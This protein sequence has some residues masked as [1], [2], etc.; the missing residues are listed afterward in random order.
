MPGYPR[1][2]LVLVLLRP[3]R[4]DGGGGIPVYV[5]EDGTYEGVDA[6]VDKDRAAAV[7][8][9]DIDARTLLFLTDVDNVYLDYMKPGQKALENI[10]VTEARKYMKGGQFPPG[11]MGPKIEAAISFLSG[12]G[13]DV[14]IT[15]LAKAKPAISGEAG[16]RIVNP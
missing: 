14:I 5:E 8:A 4:L 1:F 16:T 2:L 13:E 9:H 6:V 12:G 3:A 15:S 7:L 10:S 11:S